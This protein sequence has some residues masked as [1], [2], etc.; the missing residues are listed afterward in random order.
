MKALQRHLGDP[1]HVSR[2][3]RRESRGEDANDDDGDRTS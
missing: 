2:V 3:R 1:R